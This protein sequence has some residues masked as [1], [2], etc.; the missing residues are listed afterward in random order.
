MRHVISYITNPLIELRCGALDEN[1]VIL[2]AVM[3]K[4]SDEMLYETWFNYHANQKECHD[5]AMQ[6]RF[7]II[8]FQPE[9]ARTLE[10]NN[11]FRSAFAN[12]N[13][14]IAE[15]PAWSLSQFDAARAE[16]Y[17]KYAEVSDLWDEIR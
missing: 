5:M 8:F 16:I 2:I 17:K 9:K 13:A 11:P 15:R 3:V 7:P 1:G 10:I 12:A 14:I 4:F 6:E